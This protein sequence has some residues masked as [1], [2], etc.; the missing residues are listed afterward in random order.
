M[1]G[2]ARRAIR[3]DVSAVDTAVKWPDTDSTVKN[4]TASSVVGFTSLAA[5]T[6]L[7]FGF[8]VYETIGR[9]PVLTVLKALILIGLAAGIVIEGRAR[10]GPNGGAGAEVRGARGP[11]AGVPPGIGGTLAEFVAVVAGA[12]VTFL[13]G[14]EFNLTPVVASALIGLIGATALKRLAVPIFCGSFVGMC[15]PEIFVSLGWVALAGL[16]AGLIFVAARDVFNGFGGKLGTIAFTGALAASVIFGCRL[17]GPLIPGPEVTF[18]ILGYSVAGATATYLLSVRLAN[19][20]VVASALVGLAGGLLLPAAHGP[21]LGSTLA[22]I[23]FCA[24]FVGMTA[25]ERLDRVALVSAA[26]LVCGVVFIFTVPHLGGAGGK[27]GTIAFGS[28]IAVHAIA[29]AVRRRLRRS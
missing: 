18:W 14:V 2:V 3:H 11:G 17:T 13:V 10:F 28:T 21:V 23:V 20:P 6:V 9:A 16:I 19:G 12:T 26:G 27:L 8:S 1:R 29:L 22:V 24:S 4:S 7:L 25:T 15:S 5:T